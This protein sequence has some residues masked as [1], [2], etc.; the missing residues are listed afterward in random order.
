MEQ[1]MPS[2]T[3]EY[4]R[5]EL[6]QHSSCQSCSGEYLFWCCCY[7][8]A[9]APIRNYVLNET[10]IACSLC[11]K[12]Y[13]KPTSMN[14]N[15]LISSSLSILI[16]TMQSTEKHMQ[17]RRVSHFYLL[18]LGSS[19]HTNNKR[20]WKWYPLEPTRSRWTLRRRRR[21]SSKSSLWI[22]SSHR[23]IL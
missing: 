16:G 6:S 19:K 23:G 13:E 20:C 11:S 10:S 3:R 22:W 15:C 21:L 8:N 1:A 12:L 14:P 18:I 4:R 5:R 9:N 7:Q 2:G 17:K